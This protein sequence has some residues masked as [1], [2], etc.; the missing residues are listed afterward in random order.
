MP[1]CRSAW[2]NSAPLDEFSWNLIYE[3]FSKCDKTGILHE[4]PIGLHI[5]VIAFSF[6]LRMRNVS[7][8]SC[9]KNKNT[10]CS[11]TPPTP[12]KSCCLWDKVVVHCRAAQGTDDNMA[13]LHFF[14][15][16][17]VYRH[18]LGICNTYCP[19]TATV[20]APTPLSIT[21]YVQCLLL[22]LVSFYNCHTSYDFVPNILKFGWLNWK[23]LRY[24]AYGRDN[25]GFLFAVY[26]I[27][28]SLIGTF[29]V[30]S[31]CVERCV[32]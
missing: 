24:Q 31:N 12:G 6:L 26:W 7:D 2:N 5:F 20:V 13:H 19:S 30:S 11:V 17:L 28:R 21:F 27:I 14:L 29:N 16:N 32:S 8:K 4:D 25:I 10:L 3:Y 22:I 18:T 23:L 1:V 9:R 15:G